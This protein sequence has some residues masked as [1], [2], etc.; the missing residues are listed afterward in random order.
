MGG[1]LRV[2]Y[3]NGEDSALQLA[4]RV[5]ANADGRVIQPTTLFVPSSGQDG[6]GDECA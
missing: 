4:G 5:F 3:G 1:D 6:D 2:D